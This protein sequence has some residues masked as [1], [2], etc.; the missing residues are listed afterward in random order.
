ML[1]N[2]SELSLN[3]IKINKFL[4]KNIKKSVQKNNLSTKKYYFR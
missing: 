2:F 3:I 1:N 4:T